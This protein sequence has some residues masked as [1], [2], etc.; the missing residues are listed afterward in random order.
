[1]SDT[2]PNGPAPEES[3]TPAA[4]AGEG[5]GLIADGADSVHAGT[6]DV[7]SAAA[8]PAADAA[9]GATATDVGDAQSSDT[10]TAGSDGGQVVAE[11]AP[12]EVPAPVEEL[13]DT[14]AEVEAPAAGETPQ[15]VSTKVSEEPDDA[16]GTTA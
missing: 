9:E 3:A 12:A 6:T 1:M 16:T 14:P 10:T 7:G 15:P 4:P 2:D 8:Q 13:V 11:D 5:D